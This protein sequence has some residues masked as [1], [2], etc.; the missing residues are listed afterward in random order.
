MGR[1][2]HFSGGRGSLSYDIDL[3]VIYLF[4]IYLFVIVANYNANAGGRF[5]ENPPFSWQGT[6]RIGA[7]KQVVI[8]GRL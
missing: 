6:G 7:N 4:A 8:Q 5:S 3:F 1:R 2:G